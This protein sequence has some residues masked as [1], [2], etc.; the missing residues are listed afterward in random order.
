MAADTNAYAAV[1]RRH[2]DPQM[3]KWGI[4]ALHGFRVRYAIAISCEVF[5]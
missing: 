5:Y 3:R 4:E 1:L 2:I